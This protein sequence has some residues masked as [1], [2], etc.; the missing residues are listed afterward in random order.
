MRNIKVWDFRNISL[1]ISMRIFILHFRG[2]GLAAYESKPD[3][4][5]KL[6]TKS[7]LFCSYDVGRFLLNNFILISFLKTGL[8]VL[9][10]EVGL[11]FALSTATGL[12]GAIVEKTPAREERASGLDLYPASERTRIAQLT[13]E[14]QL[15]RKVFLK[16]SLIKTSCFIVYNVIIRCLSIVH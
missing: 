10:S 8:L 12:L 2:S 15:L 1:H 14:P 11:H 3:T 13:S 6:T 16:P 7:T 5:I 4:V 9:K